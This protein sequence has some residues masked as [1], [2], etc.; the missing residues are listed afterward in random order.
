MNLTMNAKEPPAIIDAAQAEAY[1]PSRREWYSWVQH[2]AIPN[3]CYFRSGRSIWFIRARLEGW[4][5]VNANGTRP[6]DAP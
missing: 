1:G 3:D 6:K 5:G 4:L 2:R